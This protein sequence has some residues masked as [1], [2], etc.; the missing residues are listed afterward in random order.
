MINGTHITGNC[1][2]GNH[3]WFGMNVSMMNDRR[4]DINDPN[5]GPI[6]G[7]YVKIG[8]GACLLP[9]ITIGEYAT[10]A[11]GAVVT[12]DVPAYAIVAGVPAKIIGE[13]PRE[14]AK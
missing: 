7:D 4:F 5:K 14:E 10:V 8:G 13:N 3:V 2:I 11:A 12:K 1:Y 9:E 6:I